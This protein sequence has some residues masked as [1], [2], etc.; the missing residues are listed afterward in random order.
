MSERVNIVLCI[1]SFLL[2]LLSMVFIFLTLR[3]NR[4]ILEQ[5]DKHFTESKR[6]GNQPFLQMELIAGL[7]NGIPDYEII[8]PCENSTGE[9]ARDICKIKNVGN[10]TAAN[11]VF[12]WKME[13]QSN[14]DVFPVNAV[15]KGDEYIFQVTLENMLDCDSLKCVLLW[16]YNDILGYTYEQKSNLYYVAGRLDCIENDSPAF[17]GEVKYKLP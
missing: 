5:S 16:S 7:S 13:K 10:G 14:S 2:A 15:M 4:R 6:L 9:C 17:L 8:I 3:Q 12:T 1:L 11:L